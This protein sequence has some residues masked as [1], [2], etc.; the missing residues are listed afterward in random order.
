MQRLSYIETSKVIQPLSSSFIVLFLSF[1]CK[2]KPLN[3]Q[4]M[5]G[6]VERGAELHGS[7]FNTSEL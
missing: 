3:K 5:Q 4:E 2:L 1:Y 7:P 6:V